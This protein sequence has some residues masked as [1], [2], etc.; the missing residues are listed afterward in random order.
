MTTIA[1]A[2]ADRRCCKAIK[3]TAQ[4]VLGTVV[5]EEQK[6]FKEDGE[7]NSGEQNK[8][9]FALEN[10]KKYMQSNPLQKCPGM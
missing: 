10:S 9:M 3:R 2:A 8:F 7:T 1:A 5:K 4:D 6:N